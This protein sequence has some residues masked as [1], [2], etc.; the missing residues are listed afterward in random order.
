M[1]QGVEENFDPTAHLTEEQRVKHAADRLDHHMNQ[2]F[3]DRTAAQ[4]EADNQDTWT[5]AALIDQGINANW[6]TEI[7]TIFH[8]LVSFFVGDKIHGDRAA[9]REDSRI[10]YDPKP[11]SPITTPQDMPA[12]YAYYRSM[13]AGKGLEQA[14]QNFGEA[15][16]TARHD[17]AANST[18]NPNPQPIMSNNAKI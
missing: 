1:P 11:D 10:A 16:E 8:K 7:S 2:T 18:L 3:G 9:S 5:K 14:G 17:N 12:A 4:V 6:L 13:E 15:F